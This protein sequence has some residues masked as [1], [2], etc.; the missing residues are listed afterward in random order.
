VDVPLPAREPL[1]EV[2]ALCVGVVVEERQRVAVP[3]PVRDAL[4]ERDGKALADEVRQSDGDVLSLR[5]LVGLPLGK[6][7]T[8]CVGVMVEN[9]LSVA[10]PLAV[11]DV[12]GECE[13]DPLFDDVGH[14]DGHVLPLR[15]LLGLPLGEG[16]ILSVDEVVEN[17]HSVAVP[18]PVLDALV[19]SEGEEVAVEVGHGE[20]D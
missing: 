8:L 19:E 7:L 2:F 15:E 11:R 17:R 1:G 20:G 3:L 12:L 5:K 14:F 16:L 13:G 18:L 9:R 10:V 6:W 4:G